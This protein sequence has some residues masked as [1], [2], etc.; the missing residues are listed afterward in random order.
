[1]LQS[2][3]KAGGDKA[4]ADYK[5]SRGFES[6]L[7]KMGQVTY[8]FEYQVALE[9]FQ[10]KYPD[11]SVEEDPFAKRPEDAN[12]RME[13]SQPFV[14]SG[15]RTCLGLFC[16]VVQAYAL[17]AEEP[18]PP[19]AG[20]GSGCLSPHRVSDGCG[21]VLGRRLREI[22]IGCYGVWDRPSEGAA[23]CG[24]AGVVCCCGIGCCIS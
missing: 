8:E 6:G 12:V 23:S 22:V 21:E 7:E 15:S 14:I 9:R 18:S 3:L 11:S 1:M 10:A 19:E 20:A 2:E 5:K 13:A 24:A 17:Q 4:I 16:T